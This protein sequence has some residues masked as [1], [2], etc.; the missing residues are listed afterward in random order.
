MKKI[1]SLIDSY[2]DER[3]EVNVQGRQPPHTARSI[4]T[5]NHNSFS[6]FANIGK[7]RSFSDGPPKLHSY[8]AD[9]SDVA[10]D[11]GH[12]TTHEECCYDNKSI[13]AT[14]KIPRTTPATGI[15][16]HAPNRIARHG[17]GHRRPPVSHEAGATATT[18]VV[19][20]AE[21]GHE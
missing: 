4:L 13:Q 14:W 21:R 6:E 20:W 3:E 16:T 1:F 5:N 17:G 10:A 11:N 9:Q 15:C 18:A 8:T 7:I 2:D 12:F 19:Q